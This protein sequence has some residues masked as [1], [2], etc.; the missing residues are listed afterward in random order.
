MPN[1]DIAETRLF[2]SSRTRLTHAYA[3]LAL[4]SR[5]IALGRRLLTV[6][7]RPCAT[8]LSGPSSFPGWG[9]TDSDAL[10][11][12]AAAPVSSPAG[13]CPFGVP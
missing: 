5:V 8:V 10:R 9:S 4:A 11:N 13:F 1:K 6:R 7:P 3:K 12:V 2:V